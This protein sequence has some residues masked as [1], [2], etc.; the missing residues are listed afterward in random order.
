MTEQNNHQLIEID[1]PEIDPE[2]IMVEI[3][4]RM[5]VERKKRKYDEQSFPKFGQS[6]L[7]NQ[8]ADLEIDSELYR[9]LE[10][11]NNAIGDIN[12]SAH[13]AESP[14]TRVPILGNI[15]GMIRANAHQ[16]VLFYVNRTTSRQTTVNEEMLNVLNRLT[17]LVHEQSETIEILQAELETSMLETPVLETSI[18][19]QAQ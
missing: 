9:F 8:L 11:A 12:T 1:D 19:K 4:R 3:R 17:I 13:L 16:L 5:W 7:F 6:D 2:K 18:E 10:K 15:W 14:A